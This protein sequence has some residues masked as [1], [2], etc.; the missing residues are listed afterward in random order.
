MDS[1]LS[2]QSSRESRTPPWIRALRGI[3]LVGIVAGLLLVAWGLIEPYLIDE[4]AYTVHLVGL[5][6]GWE[7]QEVA[8]ISDFQVGMWGDNLPTVRRIGER[9][10]QRR[11]AAVLILGDFIYHGGE[12]PERRIG[13]AVELVRPLT[14][15]DLTV[16]AVLGNHDYSVVN[17]TD[18]TVDAGRARRLREALEGIGVTVL[19]NESLALESTA[20]SALHLVG[21]GSFMAGRSR[22]EEALEGLPAGAPRLVIMHNPRSFEH[23]PA[24]S[25]PVALAGHTHGGQ[26]RLPFTPA[27]SWV[28]FRHEDEVHIDGWIHDYGAP[29]NRLYV[30]RGI[31]FSRIPLRLNCPPEVTWLTLAAEDT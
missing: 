20:G 27:W 2:R 1:V 31:G 3:L 14:E 26:F 11:P 15:A 28:S 10:V 18:P 21:V 5:P 19:E 13:T 12:R 23:L 9:I 8:V 6:E 29:G 22:P 4:T 25:A 30:N 16:V 7:G 17:Y 24:A